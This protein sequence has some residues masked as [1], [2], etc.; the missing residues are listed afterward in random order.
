MANISIVGGKLRSTL[1]TKLGWFLSSLAKVSTDE[2]DM[3]PI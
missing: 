2:T 1:D 3:K